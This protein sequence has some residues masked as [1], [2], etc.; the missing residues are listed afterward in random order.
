MRLPIQNALYYPNR[1]HLS[2]KRLDLFELGNLTFERPDTDTFKGLKL[3][4]EAMKRG[5]NIPTAFNAANERAV[6]LFL[7]KKIKYL[8][9]VEIIEQSMNECKYIDNP[10]I[11]EI[12]K[13]EKEVYNFIDGRW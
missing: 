12:L 3:A 11:D 4:Y 10:S 2:G 9:I 13:T 8:D 1:C 5:G 6:A 7:D